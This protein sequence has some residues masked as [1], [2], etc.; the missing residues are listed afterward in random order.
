MYNQAGRHRRTHRL[1][2]EVDP[3][4]PE[5]IENLRRIIDIGNWTRQKTTKSHTFI[6]H[7]FNK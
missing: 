3:S 5:V 4:F 6:S 1:D 2:F 7:K